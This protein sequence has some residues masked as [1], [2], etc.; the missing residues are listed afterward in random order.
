VGVRAD[1][2][3]AERSR[4]FGS[5]ILMLLLLC[6]L[7]LLLVFATSPLPVGTNTMLRGLSMLP[8]LFALTARWN[9]LGTCTLPDTACVGVSATDGCCAS[10]CVSRCVSR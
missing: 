5:L 2:G 6:V 10:R 1:I 4:V 3:D 9:S 8:I 7:L